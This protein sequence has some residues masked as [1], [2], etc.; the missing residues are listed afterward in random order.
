[1]P[2][3]IH[4][5]FQTILLG[6]SPLELDLRVLDQLPLSEAS[7]AIL[8]GVGREFNRFIELQNRSLDWPII[9]DFFQALV[10]GNP[11]PSP[12]TLNS[13]KYALKKLLLNQL[14]FQNSP[15][16]RVA[17]DQHFQT[18]RPHR[19]DPRVHEGEYLSEREISCLV[20]AC[21]DGKERQIRLGVI[22]QALFETGCRISELLG[23]RLSDC[24]P[25]DNHVV[26]RI[27]GKGN[28][29]RQVYL[30]I[31]TQSMARTFFQGKTW[32]FE[33]ERGTPIFRNNIFRSIQRESQ[34]AGLDGSIHPHTFRHSCAMHLL[35][36]RRL[37]PKAVSEYLGHSDVSITLKTYIHEMPG[38]S[39]VLDIDN[40][41]SVD[42]LG[43]DPRRGNSL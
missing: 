12:A 1:M 13:K 18:L 26:I 17:L 3:P 6:E 33:S 8:L 39:D 16:A 9:Q 14:G 43:K 35:K 24:E 5:S 20:R 37:N 15:M 38:A 36:I 31:K 10:N 42:D 32:L 29:E 25:R 11:P 40:P 4:S 21:Y 7:K 22:I 23:I 2:G 30:K 41:T 19:L 27:L 28:K 34:R